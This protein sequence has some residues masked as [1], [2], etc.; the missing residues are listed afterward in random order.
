MNQVKP[1]ATLA[2][3]RHIIHVSESAKTAR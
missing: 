3:W 1:N 2:Y